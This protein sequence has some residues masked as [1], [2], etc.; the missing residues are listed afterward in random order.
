[1]QLA[2]ESR[3]SSLVME[4]S[5]HPHVLPAAKYPNTAATIVAVLQLQEEATE[6][7]L[8]VAWM[9]LRLEKSSTAA[10]PHRRNN[11]KLVLCSHARVLQ[12]R[13]ALL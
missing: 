10:P 12:V 2:V 13:R 1:M 9:H 5:R 6:G 8:G 11:L 7:G 3:P 4:S